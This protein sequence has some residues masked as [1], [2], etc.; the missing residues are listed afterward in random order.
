MP[1]VL[2]VISDTHGVIRPQALDALRG[3][4]RILH[5]G[6][7]GS[8]EVLEALRALAP[9]TAV[10]GNVDRGALAAALPATETVVVEEAAI[11]LI[12]DVSDLDLDPAAAAL[13]AVVSGHSHRASNHWAGDVLYLNPGSAGP[14]RFGGRLSVARLTITGGALHAEIIALT[15]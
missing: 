2:G 9:L 12:H 3:A 14:R 7:V 6:D 5:A 10:R 8:Q 4:D 11:H 15:A 1:T 13:R